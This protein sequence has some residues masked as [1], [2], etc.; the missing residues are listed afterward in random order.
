MRIADN[1]ASSLVKYFHKELN[2]LYPE[3]ELDAIL[4]E[5]FRHYL[6]LST[7]NT[8]GFNEL[9]LNQSDV[10]LVYDACKALKRQEPLQYILGETW[11]YG[12]PIGVNRQVLIPRPE[13][14]ELVDIMIRENSGARSFLDIGTGSGCI[15]LALAKNLP[16]AIA[17]ACDISEGALQTAM[18]NAEKLRLTVRFFRCD[19]RSGKDLAEK[20]GRKYDLIVSNPPYVKR[21]ESELMEKNVRNHE[22]DIALFVDDEDPILFY[23]SILEASSS[24]LNPHGK[25]YFELN[26]LTAEDVEL[27]AKSTG[28]FSQVGLIKDMSGKMRFLRAEKR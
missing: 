23:R 21:S 15:A 7:D 24:L 14:E 1:S 26:P 5:V 12:L 11:F 6:G 22:P 25:L 16:E 27:H 18:G 17:E 28:Q 2:G 4:R 19:A 3:R 13:T 10:L 9:R 20:S 8:A